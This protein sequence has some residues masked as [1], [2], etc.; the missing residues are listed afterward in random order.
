VAGPLTQERD[1][2]T[3]VPEGVCRPNLIS[4]SQEPNPC[5]FFICS[6]TRH[7]MQKGRQLAY[8]LLTATA[9]VVGLMF[10]RAMSSSLPSLTFEFFVNR[11]TYV[12]VFAATAIL[13]SVLGF[14]LRRR[15]DELRRLSTTD[16]L[17]GLPNRRA[18][19]ARLRDEWRRASRY[20]TP[21]SLLLIDI[22]GLKRINDERGHAAGD[23]VLSTAAHGIQATMR[24][25]DFGA[26][27]GGDEFAIV[28]P[29]TVR[30]A[31]QH[32][33]QRLL[34]HVSEQARARDAEVTVSVGVATFEPRSNPSATA[35]SLV[36][37][38]DDALYQ[39]KH[40]GRNRV[41][42]A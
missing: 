12:Y 7:M 37:S 18:F 38:A 20:T 10:V 28:A 24:V 13:F 30:N 5:L 35:D 25:T 1:A 9:V 36:K 3:A 41:R 27:W 8:A 14:V 16:A 4:S 32:L 11:L 21:L 17:T 31:A 34:G 33:A 23:E 22:D 42:V 40:E 19:Q 15:I 26:R 39:A 29:N 6:N 2:A